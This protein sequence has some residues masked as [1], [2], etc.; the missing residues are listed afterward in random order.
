MPWSDFDRS[1]ISGTRWV[2]EVDSS[3]SNVCVSWYML[4]CGD[5]YLG[6]VEVS[7]GTRP[8]AIRVSLWLLS[9]NDARRLALY[10]DMKMKGER[11]LN[12]LGAE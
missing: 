8:I 5:A 2:W 12:G 4:D 1:D 3:E 10:R 9:C 11:K 7:P 6:P